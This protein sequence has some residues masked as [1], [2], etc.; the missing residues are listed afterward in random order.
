MRNIAMLGVRGLSNSDICSS[1]EDLHAHIQATVMMPEI[2]TKINQFSATTAV[3]LQTLVLQTL[4]VN[5][6]SVVVVTAREISPTN[7]W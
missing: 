1:S 4:V 7:G 2:N 3:V 5:K 6:Q